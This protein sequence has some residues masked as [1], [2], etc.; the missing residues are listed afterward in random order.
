[1]KIRIKL[2]S[3]VNETEQKVLLAYLDKH[4]LVYDNQLNLEVPENF[5]FSELNV[6]SFIEE[7]IKPKYPLAGKKQKETIIDIKGLKIGGNNFTII[8]GP[9][10][11]ESE[12]QLLET[13][14]ACKEA[15]AVILR[16]GA[17]KPR[18]SPYAFQGLGIEG[19]RLLNK[20]GTSLKMPVISEIPDA[21]FLNEFIEYCDIIQVGAR[22][23]QN[24][25]L[26]KA[27]GKIN[28]PIL[29]K[30]G[31]AATIEEWL[32]SAEYLLSYGNPNVILCE[33][34][35]RTFDN[36]LR[37]CLDLGAVLAVKELSH[38]PVFVDPSHG[39]GHHSYVNGLSRAALAVGAD[40]LLIEV[41]NNP[42]CALSDG[43]QSLKPEKFGQLIRDLK[44]IAPLI[45]K[46]IS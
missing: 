18:T 42:D 28:K 25:Q 33:R 24:F 37:N 8:G 32:F 15:G 13:A 9:C 46:K 7:I 45:D 10:S 31:L 39:S 35:I 11:V 14:K 4:K 17:F 30:R 44:K 34:G 16:G 41:H 26:L 20:V 1:M 21:E 38:L 2:N 5:D 40:G 29:L 23:M 6:F 36:T 19:L 3:D 12:S 22:N 43:I 27:L